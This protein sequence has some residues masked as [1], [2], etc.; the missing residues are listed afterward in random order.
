M[1]KN[2]HHPANSTLEP[3]LC[4]I[5]GNLQRS[6]TNYLYR[7]LREHPD[8]TGPGPIWEDRF[9]SYSEVL[10][11][12]TNS[13]YK[14]WN[15]KWEVHKKIGPQETLLRCFGDAISRFLKLQLAG[16]TVNKPASNQGFTEENGPKILLTKT[17]SVVG[18]ENFFDLFP[19]FYL[20]LIIRD[21]RAVVESGVRTFD[22]NYE[23]AMRKWRAGAHAILD[24]KEKYQNSNKKLL[25]V[26]YEDLFMDEKSE[27][28]K[29]FA[30]LGLDPGLFDF[31]LTKSLGVTGSSETR[32]QASAVH[33][34]VTEKSKDF[35]PL[36]R[37]SNWDRKKHERFNWI[38]GRY[39]SRLGYDIE[40]ISS[41]RHLY[42]IRNRFFDLKR[43]LRKICLRS[44]RRIAYGAK[45]FGLTLKDRDRF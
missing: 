21:G 45:K 9:V 12:Y 25:I 22:W 27:L 18:S 32:K 40:A 38:A 14:S 36:A 1:Q 24:L 28:L 6:G 43:I 26:K 5:L 16:D 44:V 39:M 29:I 11:K 15:P 17:P 7:L 41:N 35:N 42:V 19:D 23:N 13:I 33:W 2:M 34:Q 3:K 4:F 8:C 30:F 10:T 31:D 37:F 20:I